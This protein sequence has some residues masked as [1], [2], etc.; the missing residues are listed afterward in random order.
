MLLILWILLSALRL[1]TLVNL[2]FR[3]FW[4]PTL[5]L[6]I[7]KLLSSFLCIGKVTLYLKVPG[8]VG[9]DDQLSRYPLCFSPP[10]KTNIMDN[11]CLG[12]GS[13]VIVGLV[14][15]PLFFITLFVYLMV[16]FYIIFFFSYILLFLS[17]LIHFVLLNLDMC[18]Q[19]YGHLKLQRSMKCI[20]RFEMQLCVMC[21]MWVAVH[22]SC[23]C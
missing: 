19:S 1:T 22:H 14:G 12:G 10:S 8:S 16:K 11:V 2:S 3:I 20:V 9:L 5:S 18:I 7:A 15:L 13:D 21:S 6:F 17:F 4:I 23:K